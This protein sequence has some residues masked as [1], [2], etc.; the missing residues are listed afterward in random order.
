MQREGGS[1]SRR[2]KREGRGG[3]AVSLAPEM[4]RT[5]PSAP[6][7]SRWGRDNASLAFAVL[8][9]F[10]SS[11]F[12]VPEATFLL[13]LSTFPQ[14]SVR[15]TQNKGG[16]PFAM[17]HKRRGK[18]KFDMAL[19][20][21]YGGSRTTHAFLKLPARKERVDKKKEGNKR[22]EPSRI[23]PPSTM[24]RTRPQGLGVECS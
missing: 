22:A 19:L 6:G 5:A 21:T 23:S 4:G 8:V 11:P 9:R 17:S 1:A 7:T 18:A 14:S 13:L 12:F 24:S 3:A 20:Q 15:H 2:R 10:P 16:S